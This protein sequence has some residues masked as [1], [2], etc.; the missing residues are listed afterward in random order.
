MVSRSCGRLS[1]AHSSRA[2]CYAPHVTQRT[3]FLISK[4]KDARLS[5]GWAS[6]QLWRSKLSRRTMHGS[7]FFKNRSLL[8]DLQVCGWT[9]RAR[10][11]R[12]VD[13]E[14]ALE[15]YCPTCS[16]L[17]PVEVVRRPDDAKRSFPTGI[18]RHS[19]RQNGRRRMEAPTAFNSSSRHNHRRTE[20]A[21]EGPVVGLVVIRGA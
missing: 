18:R 1:A 8:K 17:K 19:H 12:A 15:K 10:K 7:C 2:D 16:E 20:L 6:E 9:V 5:Q 11:E 3:S 13:P 4:M 21:A 14:M